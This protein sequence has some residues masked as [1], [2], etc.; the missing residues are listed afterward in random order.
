MK[1]IYFKHALG[2]IGTNEGFEL[3]VQNEQ[4]QVMIGNIPKNQKLYIGPNA[5]DE[6]LEF[7]YVISGHIQ[8][9]IDGEIVEVK[10]GDSF[11]IRDLEEDVVGH[12]EED[13]KILY[14]TTEP[15]YAN[16]S[17]ELKEL[18]KVLNQ[19]EQKDCYTKGHSTRVAMYAAT[20][21]QHSEKNIASAKKL[22]YAAQLH[23]IGKCK[24]AD[25]ILQKPGRFTPEEREEMNKHSLYS[26][27]MLREEFQFD[28]EIC[29]MVECHHERYDG[30]GYP[31]GLKGEE[32][33]IEARIIAIVDTFDAITTK[34][35]YQPART[36]EEAIEEMNRFAHE[37]DPEFFE[38][39]K[40]L[41][42]SGHIHPDKLP[43]DCR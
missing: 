13:T 39:F 10:A 32:I 18:R 17:D 30:S 36:I 33:P 35:P 24:I 11:Y 43:L 42:R 7:L 5:L 20:F 1:G 4:T 6:T 14:Y 8:F 16:I 34:R 19:I 3:V 2:S 12:M 22:G 9:K 28:E 27:K 41:V 15:H 40:K 38:I 21:L 25:E 23:D 37:F 29:H 26:A 31:Y